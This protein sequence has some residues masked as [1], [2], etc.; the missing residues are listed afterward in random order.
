M[1]MS[2]VSVTYFAQ[3][4]MSKKRF[5]PMSLPSLPDIQH[6]ETYVAIQISNRVSIA[7][8]LTVKTCERCLS[9]VPGRVGLWEGV[10]FVPCHYISI[11]DYQHVETYLAIRISNLDSIASKLTAKTCERCLSNMPGWVRLWEGVT[12][13]GR[14]RGMT[15]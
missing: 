14:R 11:P 13:D 5:C 8:K 2:H 6:V 4:H 3:C 15:R 12:G 1:I 10:S 7:S 9:N